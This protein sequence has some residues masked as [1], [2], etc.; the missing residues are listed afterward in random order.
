MVFQA[1]LNLESS[2]QELEK[3]IVGEI[4]KAFETYTQIMR[5][6]GQQMLN[7]VNRIDQ[8]I[9][10]LPPDKE[11]I[12]FVRRDPNMVDPSVPVRTFD[13]VEYPGIHHP[14]T[15]E[16]RSGQLERRSKYLKSYTAGWYVLS[17]THLHEL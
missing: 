8:Q 6:D 1:Y 13:G 4:Q 2:G 12:E 10:Q 15:I 11:W 3:I 14:S 17:P 5:R 16:V 7:A 9:L